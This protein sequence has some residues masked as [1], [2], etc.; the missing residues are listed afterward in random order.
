MTAMANDI[1]D[2]LPMQF[3]AAKDTLRDSDTPGAAGDEFVAVLM[4]LDDT[5]ASALALT[6]LLVAAAQLVMLGNQPSPRKCL[7]A[8]G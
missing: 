1:G 5:Q 7:P 8:W 4:D 6:R 3:M 2:Q